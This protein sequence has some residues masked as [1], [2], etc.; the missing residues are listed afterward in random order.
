[1]CIRELK[2]QQELSKKEEWFIKK[3]MIE[4]P[5]NQHY[6]E[7]DGSD[8]KQFKRFTQYKTFNQQDLVRNQNNNFRH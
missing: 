8:N 6:S 2:S 7:K 5:V 3:W 1:M 4:K